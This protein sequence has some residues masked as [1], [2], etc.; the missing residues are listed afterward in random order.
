MCWCSRSLSWASLM[1]PFATPVVSQVGSWLCHMSVCPRTSWWLASAKAT[2][3]SAP[4]QSNWPWVPPDHLARPP[5]PP[6]SARPYNREHSRWLNLDGRPANGSDTPQ[7]TGKGA[8]IVSTHRA[9]LFTR[10]DLR[11]AKEYRRHREHPLTRMRCA[12]GTLFQPR[13]NTDRAGRSLSLRGGR[14]AGCRAG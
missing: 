3:W 13:C 6:S 5:T 8:W 1:V 4:D 14:P 12:E 2:T 9:R 7:P 11:D 10:D